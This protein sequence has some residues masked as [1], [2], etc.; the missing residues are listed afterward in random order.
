M[1]SNAQRRLQAIQAH[2][3]PTATDDPQSHVHSNLTA[4]EFAHGIQTLSV[5][6]IFLLQCSL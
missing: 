3:L 5:M 4:G 2:L 1:E 6:I